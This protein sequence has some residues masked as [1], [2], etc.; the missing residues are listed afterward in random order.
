MAG[1]HRVS[2]CGLAV[3]ADDASGDIDRLFMSIWWEMN[4]LCGASS[5]RHVGAAA[6]NHVSGD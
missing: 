6:H 1:E 2:C 5:G 4:W 3:D